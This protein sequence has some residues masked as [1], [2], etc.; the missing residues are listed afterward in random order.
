MVAEVIAEAE[1]RF[2]VIGI[3]K[4]RSKGEATS[5]RAREA[6]STA[7]VWAM[8]ELARRGLSVERIAAALGSDRR[9]VEEAIG[10]RLDDGDDDD[11]LEDPPRS[12]PTRML[13]V[14]GER[15][16]CANDSEC[17]RELL[18]ACEPY[19]PRFAS[20]PPKCPSFQR[21]GAASPSPGLG[22]WDDAQMPPDPEPEV[23]TVRSQK[24][25]LAVVGRTRQG[26]RF[27]KVA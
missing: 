1:E 19:A 8:T 16:D 24:V 20:C 9:R 18:D 2:G 10:L 27:V 11:E 6:R 25:R 3:A 12:R 21:P 17:L 22:A 13:P 7:R 23:D 15:R 5:E 26:G 4:A 14:L